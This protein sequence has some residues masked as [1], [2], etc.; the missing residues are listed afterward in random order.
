MLRVDLLWTHPDPGAAA[1][2][3]HSFDR[4]FRD[5][6]AWRTRSYEVPQDA[7]TAARAEYRGPD[8]KGYGVAVEVWDGTHCTGMALDPGRTALRSGA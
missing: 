5:G 1:P 2:A 3:E 4:L 6:G 8:D 7:I